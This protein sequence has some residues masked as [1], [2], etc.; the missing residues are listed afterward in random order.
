[1]YGGVM[2]YNWEIGVW[3]GEDEVYN[4]SKKQTNKLEAC[5]QVESMGTSR[6]AGVVPRTPRGG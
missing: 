2:G 4:Q 6:Q 3:T 5:I 1:M